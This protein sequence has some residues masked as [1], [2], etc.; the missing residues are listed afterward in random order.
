MTD[1]SYGA[2][3]KFFLLGIIYILI[4]VG[5]SWQF[6]VQE[7]DLSFNKGLCTEALDCDR[8]KIDIVLVD[9]LKAG[10]KGYSNN[11]W[12]TLATIIGA[13][14][15]VLGSAK[16]QRILE[17]S[18]SV[19]PVVQVVILS[20]FVLHALAYW[21]YQSENIHL[22]QQ[23]GGVVGSIELYSGYMISSREVIMNLI[24]DTILFV[25][26]AYIIDRIR[27]VK[28]ENDE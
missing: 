2:S 23:L 18:K 8:D 4:F 3:N 17:S 24:F 20:L 5:F 13:I 28:V 21:L 11:V 12:T 15:M 7:S 27:S 1:I 26:L 10:Q 14:G 6:V 19:V 25:L 9:Q 22:M 16:F